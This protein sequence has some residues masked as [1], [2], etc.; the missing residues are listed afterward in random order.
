[1]YKRILLV[2]ILFLYCVVAGYSFAAAKVEGNS[3]YVG[4]QKIY[5]DNGGSPTAISVS[6]NG[7]LIS[8]APVQ[9]V[10]V[11]T[12]DT[13]VYIGTAIIGTEQSAAAW[14][15][16]K[17]T[18]SGTTTTVTWA[19]GNANYDNVATDLTALTYE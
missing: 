18:T 6:G 13:S 8:Q 5:G 7:G 12:V 10:K 16:K 2:L 9:A 17:I 1:M 14:Q 4:S 3:P 19:D 11:T 15:A